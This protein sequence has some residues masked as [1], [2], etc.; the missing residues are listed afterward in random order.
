MKDLVTTCANGN[1]YFVRIHLI[2]HCV[3]CTAAHRYQPA[4]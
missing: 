1:H 4:A 3:R 2:W